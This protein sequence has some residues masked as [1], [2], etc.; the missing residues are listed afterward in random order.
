[1]E[2]SEDGT[3]YTFY[4]RDDVYFHDGGEFKFPEPRLVVAEDFVYSLSRILDPEVASPGAWIFRQVA[5]D[6]NGKPQFIAVDDTTFQIRL[7][8]P[9][10]PFINI[11]SM[12][13]CSVVPKEVVEKY[14]KEFRKHPVGTGPFRFQLWEEGIKLVLRK[15][16]HTEKDEQ[17]NASY[18]W[19]YI[20]F[21]SDK[22][23]MFMEFMKGN[24]D[25]TLGLMLVTKMLCS[26]GWQSERGAPTTDQSAE[27]TLSQYGVSGISTQRKQSGAQS[28][29]D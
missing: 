2:I 9:F 17:G 26:P 21:I 10:P 18:L 8:A 28:T 22:Q 4:L 5:L 12:K 6:E 7:S 16:E 24:L 15:N 20:T 11:L 3:L 1:M 23:A 13:Y 29:A 25:L 14:G 19:S 27:S